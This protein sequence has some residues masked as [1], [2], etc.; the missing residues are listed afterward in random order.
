MNDRLHPM[1]LSEILDR[2]A[3]LYRSRFLV[4]FGIGVIPAG[5]VLVSAAALFAVL[6]WIGSAGSSS[7]VP[8]IVLASMTLL[9]GSMIAMPACLGT[10][11]LG[12]AAMS[13]AAARVFL[14][15]KISIREAYKTAWKRGWRYLGLYVL[16]ALIIAGA[17]TVLGFVFLMFVSAGTA[18][19]AR[20]LGAGG[21]L[22]LG[23]SM[24][25]LFILVVSYVIWMLLRLCLS[26]PVTVVEQLSA[27]DALKRASMLSS[28]TRGR[29][30]L[31]YLLCTVLGWVL[32]VGVAVPAFIA[33][34]LV[35]G[36]QGPQHSETLG[37]A[38]MFVSYGSTFAVQAF[39]KPVYAIA[40]TLFYFDQRIR[41]EGFDI[42]W[43]MHQAG[44][45][46]PPAPEPEAIP[47]L[48]PSPS[49]DLAPAVHPENPF[50]RSE[51]IVETAIAPNPLQQPDEA[52]ATQP[53]LG[54][55]Q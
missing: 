13:D 3:Q 48:V 51:I 5:T 31:L 17:P 44:M 24:F 35:P 52:I 39:T 53:T 54:E 37:M 55:K 27:T 30:F 14:G 33:L 23:V 26:F 40:L 21:Q 36:L 32:A 38:M 29:I 50:A 19:F 25:L 6:A 28:G 8:S 11:A 1:T 42:E 45:V 12:T 9:F 4:F 47:W 49:P 16:K 18:L 10:T 15:E 34:A 46:A 43:M 2:T 22:L 7:S 41:K 20:Q